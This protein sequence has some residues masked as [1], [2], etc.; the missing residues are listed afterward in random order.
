MP[1][2]LHLS[3]YHDVPRCD[4][5]ALLPHQQARWLPPPYYPLYPPLHRPLTTPLSPA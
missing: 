3:I 4:L 2:H 5:E 1:G